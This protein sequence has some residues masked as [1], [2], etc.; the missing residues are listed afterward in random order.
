MAEVKT[1]KGIDEETWGEFKSF[2]ARN[3]VKLGTFFK[4]LVKE[5]EKNSATFWEKILN[6]EKILS[7]TEADDIEK[8]VTRV[9]AEN[10]FRT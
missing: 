10:G 3:K 5:H 8:T 4:T 1:I 6:G 9:R 2:A 7:D